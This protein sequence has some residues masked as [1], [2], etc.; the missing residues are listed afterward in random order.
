MQWSKMMRGALGG[1]LILSF[2]S[3]AWAET[4]PS[5][6]VPDAEPRSIEKSMWVR[7]DRVVD[8]YVLV[9]APCPRSRQ[10]MFRR[11]GYR[12]VQR[13]AQLGDRTIF[14]DRVYHA[15]QLGTEVRA[16]RL[17]SRIGHRVRLTLRRAGLR[18]KVL[19]TEVR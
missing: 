9:S 13:A 10:L 1:A 4:P 5:E 17:K 3:G 11:R 18:G 15:Y 7:I 2:G 12:F 16:K 8:G 14:Q 19:V 6:P